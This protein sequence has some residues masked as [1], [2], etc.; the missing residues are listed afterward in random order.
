MPTTA[1]CEPQ[2][3]A[4]PRPF[5]QE[6]LGSLSLQFSH[7]AI[8][9][10]MELL[11]PDALDL[12]YTQLMMGFLLFQPAPARLA[13][14]GLGGGSLAKFCH[15]HLP[16]AAI[17]V[18]EINPHVIALRQRFGVPPDSARFQVSL[19]DGADFVAAPPAPLDV[20][21]VDGFDLAGTPPALCS[22]RFYEH[23]H[24]ALAPEGLLVLNLH[25]HHADVELHLARLLS[26]FGD[27][28]LLQVNDPDGCNRIVIAA[29]DDCLSR[30]RAGM[31]RR[32]EGLD[33]EAW[34]DL[35]PAFGRVHAA[36]QRLQLER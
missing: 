22:Q 15:R 25:S 8:Q 36:W 23:C 26:L 2:E 14:I 32:P 9:S 3:P 24:A 33:E 12:S 10:R 1:A 29:R 28:N 6:T 18:V 4:H 19:G 21:M 5:V 30:P 16:G 20:L 35:R 11:R 34:S 17:E 7:S 31:L 13:M 27:R